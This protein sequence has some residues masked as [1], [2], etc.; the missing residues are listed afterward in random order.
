MDGT[1]NILAS[2]DKHPG[3]KA[4]AHTSS[5]AAI[6]RYDV[7][8]DHV[9]TEQDWNDWSTLERGDGYGV[10]KT[11]AERVVKEHF[12]DDE[13]HSAVLN[14]NVSIGPVFTKQHSVASVLMVREIIFGNK[15][16]FFPAS[17]VDVRDVATAHV[18]ALL[19]PEANKRRFILVGDADPC[20]QRELAAVASRLFPAMQFD[21]P[22]QI[23]PSI[24]QN[25]LIPLSRLPIVG[26][27]ILTPFQREIQTQR[28]FKYDNAAAKEVL[29][30]TFRDLDL[31]VR[32]AVESLVEGGYAKPRFK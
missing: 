13:R 12:R 16:V 19:T 22:A 17:F 14:P 9:F 29:G 8:L 23:P 15:T 21:A 10:A 5:C 25:V 2:V 18:N 31:S 24:M 3:I 7:P 11:E 20:D 6:Q 28:V 27:K 30:V 1:R 4:Y 32:D 26:S